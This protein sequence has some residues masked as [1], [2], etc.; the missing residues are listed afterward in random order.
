VELDARLIALAG[1]AGCLDATSFLGLDQIFPANQSG[2][3]VLLGIAI[4]RGDWTGVAHT[5]VS[6][7]AFAAG[8]VAL[9][10]VLRRRSAGAGWAPETAAA[11]SAEVVLLLVLFALWHTGP[12][13]VSI[14]LAAGAMG[15]QS[16]A[17]QRV[18]V[19]GV[20][21][22]FVTGTITRLSARVAG[23]ATTVAQDGTPALVWVSYLGGAVVGGA[24]THLWDGRAGV[25]MVALVVAGV[26][27]VARRRAA[28]RTV[29]P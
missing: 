18:G 16:L 24:V 28:R 29:A 14:G 25:A 10:L 9:G 15:I 21:T 13:T 1:A 7:A 2:N 8:V 4:G 12:V 19:A 3:T 22:T 26:A 17:A 20:S 23:G 27:L 5:G 11:L 6:L